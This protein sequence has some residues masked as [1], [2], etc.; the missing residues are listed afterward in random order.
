MNGFYSLLLVLI[1]FGA[2]SGFVNEYSTFGQPVPVGGATLNSTSVTDFGEGA[3]NQASDGSGQFFTILSFGR[4]IW[5]VIVATFAVGWLVANYMIAIGA[6]STISYAIG[7]VIQAPV[8][9]I[10]FTGFYEWLTGRNLT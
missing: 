5:S 3:V 9:F 8:S 4:I 7:V 6:D 1:C 2:V 10:T